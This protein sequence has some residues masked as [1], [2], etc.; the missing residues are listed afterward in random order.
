[1]QMIQ[2]TFQR[3]QWLQKIAKQ[4]LQKNDQ[5]QNF[6]LSVEGNTD[7]EVVYNK[8]LVEEKN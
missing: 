7:K 8:P 4:W 1:M 5:I 2:H 6:C 3:H